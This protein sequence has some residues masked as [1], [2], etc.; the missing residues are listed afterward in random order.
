MASA[1]LKNLLLVA[2]AIAVS[3]AAIVFG[4]T[5]FPNWLGVACAAIVPPLIVRQFWR[6]P[7]QTISESI[8]EA[9]Q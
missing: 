9:R 7:E 1:T 5:S 2:W 6:G 3:L 8:H 4:V